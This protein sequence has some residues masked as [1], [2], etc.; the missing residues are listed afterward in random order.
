M[1]VSKYASM[2]ARR[3][4]LEDDLQW[5]IAF[6]GRWPFMEEYLQW[7]RTL[8]QANQQEPV[9]KSTALNNI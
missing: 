9:P 1:Q 3:T 2:Q 8:D 5:K 7:K 4:S 6:N